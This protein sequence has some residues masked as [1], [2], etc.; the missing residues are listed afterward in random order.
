MAIFN[1]KRNIPKFGYIYAITHGTYIGQFIVF[2]EE[3]EYS[4]G[5]LMMKAYDGAEMTVQQINKKDVINGIK[6][7]II[8]KVRKLPKDFYTLCC[9]QY[10]HIKKTKAGENK[11][12]QE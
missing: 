2:V 5:V 7:D 10:S 6:N 9:A 3:S 11:C 1:F 12:R 4:Y 8:D